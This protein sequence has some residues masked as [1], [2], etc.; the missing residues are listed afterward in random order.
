MEKRALEEFEPFV[1]ETEK[2]GEELR[3]KQLDE[4]LSESEAKQREHIKEISTVFFH[5][6]R[7]IQE[8]HWEEIPTYENDFLTHVQKLEKHGGVYSPLQGMEREKRIAKND[9]MV[10]HNL[11]YEDEAYPTSPHLVLKENAKILFGLLGIIILLL[12]FGNFISSEKEQNTWLTLNTQPIPRWK[13]FIGKYVST[14]FT[15]LIFLVLVVIIGIFVPFI[16]GGY[17]LNLL[18]PQIIMSGDSFEIISTFHYILR[19]IGLFICASVFVFSLTLFVSKWIKNSFTTLIVTGFILVVG[20]T[21]TEVNE[22]L[23]SIWNPLYTLHMASI[24]E[25]IPQNTDWLYSLNTFIWCVIFVSFAILFPE[26]ELRFLIPSDMRNPF[27]KGM[28]KQQRGDILNSAK[29]ESRKMKR[30]GILTQ[31]SIFTALLIVLG[32]I[33]LDQQTMPK[34]KAYIDQLNHT[35]EV[36]EDSSIPFFKDEMSTLEKKFKV[37]NNVEHQLNAKN[38]KEALKFE[39]NE[40]ILLRE[41][42]KGYEKQDWI[43]LLE[44]QLHKNRFSNGEFETESGNLGSTIRTFVSS[45]SLEASIT[46]KHWLIDR[47]IQPVYSGEFINTIFHDWGSPTGD[48]HDRGKEWEEENE[49]LAAN[50]LYSLYHYFNIFLYFLPVI[51][52]LF[53]FGGGLAEE[54]GKQDT[55]RFLKTQPIGKRSLFTGKFVYS[56]GISILSSI[57]F[58]LFVVLIGT[59]FDRFGD[60]YYP[61]LHYDSKSIVE[62][63]NY[64]G[65][66]PFNMDVGYHFKPLGEVLLKNVS[67]FLCILV[68]VLTIAHVFALWFKNKFTVLA[69]TIIFT[70]VGYVLSAN[71]MENKAHLSPFTY[72][73][74]ARITNGEIATILDNSAVNVLSGV[75]VLV[76]STVILLLIGYLSLLK[77]N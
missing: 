64:A 77:K 30:R 34:E 51:L 7:S 58:I 67:L 68:F 65:N 32:F 38:M 54:R 63:A 76:I 66:R 4:E 74:I 73:D 46:E 10:E 40:L 8:E 11:G 55:I 75:V 42:I 43:P 25:T 50:G 56:I 9:W 28:T 5:W 60:W 36:I 52:F 31:T 37:D 35:A 45:L 16:F 71:F 29:F 41:A 19:A 15:I 23:H 33:V 18:Y 20:F 13:L 26:K 44:Y 22:I 59:I 57:G 17:S 12:F 6:K 62:A 21:V 48:M 47:K 3:L 49:K 24:I 72:F 53:L 1:Q 70:V 27:Q 61:I 69:S 39:Q 14:L 2:M